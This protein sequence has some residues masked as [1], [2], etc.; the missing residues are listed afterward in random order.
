MKIIFKEKY[1]YIFIYIL[2]PELRIL[3]M[4]ILWG[5]PGSFDWG[6][7][8][9]H[10]WRHFDT[11]I[12]VYFWSLIN[13]SLEPLSTKHPLIS[14]LITCIGTMY[15]IEMVSSH[16]CEMVGGG[17]GGC[18]P[19]LSSISIEVLLGN[20]VFALY[21]LVGPCRVLSENFSLVLEEVIDLH[22]SPLPSKESIH[23]W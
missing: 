18:Q 3:I 16:N 6:E 12:I 2:K 5:I 21:T 19:F 22:S 17:G 15:N 11:C 8:N 7:V 20:R 1:I 13:R 14:L 23:I 9:Y 10:S 4:K